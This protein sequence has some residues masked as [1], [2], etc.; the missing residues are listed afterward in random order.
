MPLL[1]QQQPLDVHPLFDGDAV[2]EIRL[3]FSEPGWYE[4]L[5][6][7]FEGRA[8]PVYM[9]AGFD[10][11]DIHYDRIGIRFKGN[12]SY[13]SYPGQKKS[14][15][16]KLNEFVKGQ[17]I[18]GIDSFALNNA[19]KD[20]SFVREKVYY[21]LAAAIGLPAPRVNYAAVS[22][23]GEFWGLYFLVEG[24]DGA[25][26]ESR[27]GKKEKGN[28]YKGDP[29]GTLQFRGN[30]AAPYKTLYERE[31]NE[32]NDDWSDLVTLIDTLNN[33]DLGSLGEIL[34]IE[35]ALKFLALDILTVNLD[36]Y[37][38]SGHN[39]YLYRRES[40][41]RFITFP[42]DPNEAWGNFNLGMQIDQLRRLPLQ[43]A[44]GPPN[45]PPGAPPPPPQQQN[46]RPLSQKLWADP[47][48]AA[49]YRARIREMLE[50]PAHPDT[51]IARMLLLRDLV[52]PWVERDTKKMFPTAQFESSFTE[53]FLPRPP[54]PGSPPMP[55]MPIPGLE[56][57]IRQRAAFLGPL[58]EN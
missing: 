2:H 46:P 14:F 7:N 32:D 17:K 13:R 5:R 24:V 10:W 38:G 47:E 36:S 56:P 15:K 31:N 57:F 8:D 45:P 25:F 42:W 30:T 23:N 26:I 44:P 49:V 20:P 18:Q 19:F 37:V 1:G 11:G 9:E 6:A 29:Q 16:I 28:L 22:I 51:L 4:Q 53:D 52:R 3:T 39:Y 27:F 55:V 34:D 40:D 48:L 35:A 33:R 41:R 21:E 54:G 50:G 12:S 58:V 43:F